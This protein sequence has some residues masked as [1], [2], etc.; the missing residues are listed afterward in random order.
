M[1]ET[2]IFTMLPDGRMKVVVNFTNLVENR[3][4][5]ATVQIQYNGGVVQDSLPVDASMCMC[6]VCDVLVFNFE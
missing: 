1:N 6:D 4:Y 5:S 3:N 2:A